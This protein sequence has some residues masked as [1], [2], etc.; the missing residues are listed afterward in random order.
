MA[1]NGRRGERVLFATRKVVES[2]APTSRSLSILSSLQIIS[3]ELATELTL[4]GAAHLAVAAGHRSAL[5]FF[6]SANSQ[7]II[8]R[9]FRGICG[10]K[11]TTMAAPVSAR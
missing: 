10:P 8:R 11:A 6:D 3:T 2:A 9:I 5:S 7:P 4:V 1:S